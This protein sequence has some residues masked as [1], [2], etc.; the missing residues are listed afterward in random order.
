MR[1][2]SPRHSG[3]SFEFTVYSLQ[4]TIMENIE[5]YLFMLAAIIVAFLII[6]RVVSCLVR[7]IVLIVLAVVLGYIY[8]MYL[9]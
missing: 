9:R 5:Y 2:L 3:N 6:K 1:R 8:Y 7:S 4:F